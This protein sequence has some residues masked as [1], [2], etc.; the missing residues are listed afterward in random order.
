M[1]SIL[2][3]F[4]SIN[5]VRITQKME[6]LLVRNSETSQN[7]NICHH[8]SYQTETAIFL[9]TKFEKIIMACSCLNFS[10]S[11]NTTRQQ[12]MAF[13]RGNAFCEELSDNDFP[14]VLVN[15]CCYEY[16]AK[17]SEAFCLEAKISIGI[18]LELYQ[19]HLFFFL[20][21]KNE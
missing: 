3:L 13:V 11:E 9:A 15:F 19:L 8:N 18:L 5:P 7:L 16:S 10:L 12:K 2:F 6:Y 17:A 1:C 14:A 20:T 21:N 4:K